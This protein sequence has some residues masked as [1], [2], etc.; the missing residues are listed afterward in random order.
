MLRCLVTLLVPSIALVGA[1]WSWTWKPAAGAATPRADVCPFKYGKQ[2]AYAVEIDDGPKWAYTFAVPFLAE[3]GYTDAPPGVI[4]GKAKPF[5]GG[6]A[7]IVNS[8]GANDTIV[9]WDDLKAMTAAGW[10]VLNHSFSHNGRSWGDEAGR[11]NDEQIKEDAFWSQALIAFGMGTNRAPTAYVYA[12]GYMDY[13]RGGVLGQFGV[14][15]GTRVGAA[16]PA[17]V[18]SGEINW[19]DYGRNYLDEG[20]W[21]AD[22]KG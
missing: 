18:T 22:Q 6:L 12:N 10:G 21:S 15:I 1:E 5:V 20:T 11:L 14:R 8:V 4:G 16:I 17:D 13:N 2:W 19:L 3:Y 7:V 9:N